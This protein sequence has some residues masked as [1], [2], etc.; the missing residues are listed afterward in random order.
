MSE[1]TSMVTVQAED[2][3]E[4]IVQRREFGAVADWRRA[5]A[6]A[7]TSFNLTTQSGR[8][9]YMRCMIG[10]DAQAQDSTDKPLI[11]TGW[12]LHEVDRIDDETGEV[13]PG[14]RLV[15]TTVEGQRISTGSGPL[16]DNWGHVVKC[17]ADVPQWQALKITIRKVKRAGGK[18]SYLT[19]DPLIDILDAPSPKGRK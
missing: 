6:Q 2:R 11:I 13:R 10:S 3:A 16:I 12:V 8:M 5:S 15:L 19:L 17:F 14:L 7:A 1:Q 9:E 4:P 18:G